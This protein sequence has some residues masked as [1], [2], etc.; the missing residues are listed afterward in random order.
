MAERSV[1]LPP[2]LQL[3]EFK[4]TG[5]LPSGIATQLPYAGDSQHSHSYPDASIPQHQGMATSFPT[6]MPLRPAPLDADSPD[7]S[8]A[9]RD[10]SHKPWGASQHAA[11]SSD[12]SMQVAAPATQDGNHQQ[13]TAWQQGVSL[14]DAVQQLLRRN[15]EL[16]QRL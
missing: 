7:V 8:H 2:V 14:Q 10:Q 12:W 11:A 16:L 15:A 5:K 3:L 13:A 4:S 1:L 6:Q 9:A